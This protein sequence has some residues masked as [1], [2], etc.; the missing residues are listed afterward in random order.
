MAA[1]N[2]G[3]MEVVKVLLAKGAKRDLRTKKGSTA[4]MLATTAGHH[5][6]SKVLEA[7]GANPK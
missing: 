1:A 6:I 4:L 3:H 7:A 2:E 5:N